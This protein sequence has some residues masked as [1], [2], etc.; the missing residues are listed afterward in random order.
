[1]NLI[2]IIFVFY[3][4]FL[5]GVGVWA[6]RFNKTQ[7]DYLLA[8]RR[9]GPWITAFSERASGESA[10]LLLALPW[11]AISVGLGESWAVLGILR[12]AWAAPGGSWS[13]LRWILVKCAPASMGA[14][15]SR[16]Q[17]PLGAS[18]AAPGASWRAL[19][20]LL[21]AL[22]VCLVAL[23]AVPD[24]PK[25]MLSVFT[26]SL[27]SAQ[28]D[29]PLPQSRTV[30]DTVPFFHIRYICLFKTGGFG[31]F[32]ALPDRQGNI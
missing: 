2:G 30:R 5:L 14:L 13:A 15:F 28:A 23:G 9:L 25:P 20:A 26:V 19:G 4:L 16:V 17:G 6:F 29:L 7:E 32:G 10:W 11:A 3:I 8:G 22:W 31:S 21:T 24:R 18:W 27:A 1:M 12:G